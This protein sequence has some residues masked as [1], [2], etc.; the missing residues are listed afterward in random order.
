MGGGSS[1]DGMVLR[2]KMWFSLV[3]AL[4]SWVMGASVA[5][6]PPWRY[7]HIMGA[8]VADVSPRR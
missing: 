6:V 3:G 2:L 7:T 8:S 5:A 1:G 4:L